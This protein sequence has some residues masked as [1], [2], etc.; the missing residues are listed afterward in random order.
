[1]S[2]MSLWK[3]SRP[4]SYQL[5]SIVLPLLQVPHS[6]T[7]YQGHQPAHFANN[8]LND[9]AHLPAGGAAWKRHQNLTTE[10]DGG[11]VTYLLS[12]GAE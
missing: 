2:Q 5:P 4:S 12:K 3:A 9:A 11:Q 1:M 8:S 7:A 10:R 6:A